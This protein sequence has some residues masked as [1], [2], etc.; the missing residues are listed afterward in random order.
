MQV[1]VEK[2]TSPRR[3]W[4]TL[5][6]GVVVGTIALILVVYLWPLLRYDGQKSP[7]MLSRA[8]NAG[9]I[10][11]VDALLRS[12]VDPNAD[13][14]MGYPPVVDAVEMGNVAVADRLID[15]GARLDG[16]ADDGIYIVPLRDADW[17]MLALLL[18]EGASICPTL[19][20]AESTVVELLPNPSSLDD[21]EVRSRIVAA[22]ARCE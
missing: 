21:S 13:G 7:T 1:I 12:G 10:D 19:E 18:R 4:L 17:P 11:K 15:G 2:V 6:A 16:P 5:A 8:V 14:G 9:S 3:C 22:G 20:L